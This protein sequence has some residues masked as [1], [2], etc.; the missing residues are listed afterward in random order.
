MPRKYIYNQSSLH[1][2]KRKNIV[3]YSFWLIKWR[4]HISFSPKWRHLC[5]CLNYKI[6]SD[7]ATIQIRNIVCFTKLLLQLENRKKR[8]QYIFRNTC[9]DLNLK[10]GKFWF[11]T[12][13]VP[14]CL[15]MLVQQIEQRNARLCWN[16]HHKILKTNLTNVSHHGQ[17]RGILTKLAKPKPISQL[18]HT[19]WA[20]RWSKYLE[21]FLFDI[22]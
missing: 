4:R 5:Q 16:W 22:F 17:I 9:E 3:I 10:S 7:I 12:F 6:H 8:F 2:D 18:N 15:T 14:C 20:G 1:R 19:K 11:Y 13:G 21:H